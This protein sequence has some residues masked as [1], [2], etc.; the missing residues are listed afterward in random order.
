MALKTEN[1]WSVVI[2][3]G[4]TAKAAIDGVN[5][6][7]DSMTNT[8]VIFVADRCLGGEITI[9]KSFTNDISIDLRGRDFKDPNCWFVSTRGA[10]RDAGTDVRYLITYNT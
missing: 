7:S 5:E 10:S 1:T 4:E 9:E 3:Q 6:T 8:A 2:Q